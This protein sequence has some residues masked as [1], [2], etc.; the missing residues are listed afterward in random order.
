V[1]EALTTTELGGGGGGPE[2]LPPPHPTMRK[3]KLV[4]NPIERNMM[5]P[6]QWFADGDH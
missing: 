6:L 3:A 4:T 1:G 2:S 5:I